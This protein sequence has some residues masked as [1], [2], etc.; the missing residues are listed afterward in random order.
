MDWIGGHPIL[1]VLGFP[2]ALAII[3]F[4][5]AIF[6]YRQVVAYSMFELLKYTADEDA[7]LARAKVITELLQGLE[8]A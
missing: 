1:E 3:A 4:A 7:R 6:V 5:A 8:R 2:M